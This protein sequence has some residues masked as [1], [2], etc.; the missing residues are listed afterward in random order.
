[1]LPL[2]FRS[3]DVK[4]RALMIYIATLEVSK[5]LNAALDIEYP[6]PYEA[7][8]EHSSWYSSVV[9][10]QHYSLLQ[11]LGMSSCA[12]NT[13]RSPFECTNKYGLRNSASKDFFLRG[14]R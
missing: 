10:I 13:K 3:K 1:M 14:S 12:P 7:L 9:Y 4:L 8:L 5:V 11:V 6:I 2:F